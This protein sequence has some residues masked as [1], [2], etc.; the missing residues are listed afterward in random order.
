MSSAGLAH[1]ASQEAD[2]AAQWEGTGES[3][4]TRLKAHGLADPLTWAGLRGDRDRLQRILSGLGVLETAPEVHSAEL[5]IGVGLQA[6]ARIAGEHWVER[7]ASQ[8]NF[9]LA[10]D[11]GL[12]AK[13]RKTE[14]ESALM[15]RLQATAVI[16]KPVEWKGRRFCQPEIEGDEN[17][18][19]KA[20]AADRLRWMRR[21]FAILTESAM[22][23]GRMLETPQGRDAQEEGGRHRAVPQVSTS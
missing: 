8:N 4:R 20:E 5:D 14:E 23:F 13:R 6:A 3:L 17:A 21:V 7:A 19:K 1:L 10:T 9:Q 15:T 22:P 16:T 18:R 11:F 12:A 2:W